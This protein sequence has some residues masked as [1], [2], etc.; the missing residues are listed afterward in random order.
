MSKKFYYPVRKANTPYEVELV[1]I[2]EEVYNAI[3]PHIWKNPQAYAAQWPLHLSE[4]N[5]L[6]V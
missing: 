1:P 6:D 3:Y 4:V 2:S 5:A